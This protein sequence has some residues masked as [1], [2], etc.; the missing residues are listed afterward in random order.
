[1]IGVSSEDDSEIWVDGEARRLY[2]VRPGIRGHLRHRGEQCSFSFGLRGGQ[3]DGEGKI[4]YRRRFSIPISGGTG[5]YE[6]ARGSIGFTVGRR[7]DRAEI[8]LLP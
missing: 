8:R 6:G 4:V 3:L 7:S 5:A 2:H 1:M